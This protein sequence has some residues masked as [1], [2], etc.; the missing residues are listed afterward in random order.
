MSITI[1]STPSFAAPK[2]HS[3]RLVYRASYKADFEWLVGEVLADPNNIMRGNGS[4]CR[5]MGDVH[6]GDN[7]KFAEFLDSC[8]TSIVICLPKS[9]EEPTVAG[10]RVG[11]MCLEGVDA[12][13]LHHRKSHFGISMLASAQGKGYGTEALTWLVEQA[14]LRYG[15]NKVEIAVFAWNVEALKSYKKVGFVQEGLLRKSMWQEGAFRDEVLLGMLAEEW[16]AAQK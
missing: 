16:F 7:V 9:A 8:L 1:P 14:F 15:L 5:P 10:E 4:A 13:G 2:F 12:R 11:W 3:S 6:R